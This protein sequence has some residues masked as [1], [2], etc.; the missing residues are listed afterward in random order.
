MILSLEGHL[1]LQKEAKMT[2]HE[3]QERVVNEV[4]IIK[5]RMN[6]I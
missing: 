2:V 5:K 1:E 6:E 3:D 4:S